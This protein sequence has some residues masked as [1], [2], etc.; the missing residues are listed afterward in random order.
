MKCR[1]KASEEKLKGSAHSQLKETAAMIKPD[2]TA[3]ANQ[4]SFFKRA[5]SD[6]VINGTGLTINDAVAVARYAA[7]VKIT[8]DRSVLER[9]RDSHDYIVKAA[10]EGKPIYGVTTG[11]GGMAHTL[12]SPEEASEL[13][14]NL[15]WFLKSEAG[16]PIPR[17][18]VR[19]AMLIRANSHLFGFSGLRLELIERMVTFLNANVTP[20]L[21]E[22][23]SIGASGDLIPLAD[24][25]GAL[26]GQDKC[27]SVDF[28]G[29]ILDAPSALKRLGLRPLHLLAKEGLAMVNG[30]SAMTGIAAN[31]TYDMKILL[32]L[33]MG[34]HALAIQAI[35]GSNQPLHPFIHQHKPHPGQLWVAEQ[36]L[37]LL[38][39]SRMIRDEL[40]AR[41]DHI[42]GTLIQDR[43]S[44]RCLPQYLGP[45][46]DGLVQISRQVT[47]EMNSA[48]DNPLIDPVR[49]VD[50]HGGNFLGQYIAVSM[51]QMRYYIGLLAKHLDAQIAL[52]VQP[53]F[54]NGLPPSLI[55]NPARKV[56]M[57]LKGLQ[58]C[59]NSIMPLLTFLAKPMADQYATHAEQFNQN[60]NSLGFGAA[61][62]TR[63]SVQAFQ[64]YM[65]V[66]LLFG[67]QAVDLRT[68]IE[69][70]HYD[71]RS[72]L[73]K[74]TI[75]LYEA[76]YQTVDCHPGKK[77][78][79]V[80]N[81]HEQALSEH[82]SAI[83][84]DIAEGGLI[85]RTL[86]EMLNTLAD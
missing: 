6:V 27:Y 13:Q 71:A 57:G 65:A 64:Q 10:R 14:E 86:H 40:D 45:V 49:Q 20:I 41:Q 50:Y 74:K 67:V 39:G 75:P 17:S 72:L 34:A 58:I 42:E 60:I 22:F 26:I 12:I 7:R 28:A 76:I 52:L 1:G 19:A 82:I 31:C 79:Y 47:T 46:V 51:D 61:N 11:F 15:I 18:D 56:N 33:S 63:Q 32:A 80:R 54:S 62:L 44:V 78:P 70:R 85:P 36:M 30:T 2:S 59:G 5:G 37:A 66:A 3:G 25:A 83:A 35:K 23:G 77:R 43:Y 55:G 29:E 21:R 73:S 24:I 9:V 69:A 38:A 81:D 53:E 16:Q 48:T 4:A 68:H 8:E 84:S